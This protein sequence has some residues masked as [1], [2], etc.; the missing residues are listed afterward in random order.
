MPSFRRNFH[1]GKQHAA[2]TRAPV[3]PLALSLF[4]FFPSFPSPLRPSRS[5]PLSLS[6]TVSHAPPRLKFAAIVARLPSSFQDLYVSGRRNKLAIF[7]LLIVTGI[8]R[9]V[10]TTVPR[11]S[12]ESRCPIRA[13]PVFPR[14]GGRRPPRGPRPRSIPTAVTYIRR[15]Q[16][17]CHHRC[18][19]C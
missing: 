3:L 17:F 8:I 6:P 10:D 11:R 13:V 9:L 5:F 4:L 16:H 2:C 19:G 1:R 18:R 7:A 15:W 12:L 14:R